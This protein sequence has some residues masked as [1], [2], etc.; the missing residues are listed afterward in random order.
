MQCVTAEKTPL[1]R[2]SPK[3]QAHT[4]LRM[5]SSHGDTG[6]ATTFLRHLLP[7]RGHSTNSRARTRAPTLETI[8]R[9]RCVAS[10]RQLEIK[11]KKYELWAELTVRMRTNIILNP[12]NP[13]T[14]CLLLLTKSYLL[15]EVIHMA[16]QSVRPISKTAKLF[17]S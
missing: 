3:R 17:F 14:N 9:Q 15:D 2:S 5:H 7:R 11:K 1:S 6:D 10:K 16:K 4:F 12:Q 8:P 13:S